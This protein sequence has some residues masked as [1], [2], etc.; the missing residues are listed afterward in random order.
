[1]L[2][3]SKINNRPDKLL[4]SRLIKLAFS[5][6]TL[7]TA[8]IL[9]FLYPE[10]H[11]YL[12]ALTAVLAS[13]CLLQT[14][15]TLD[16]G[17]E[18]ISYGGFA[19]EIIYNDFQPKRIENALGEA[20]IQNDPAKDLIKTLPVLNFLEQNLAEGSAN[21]ANFYRLQTACLNLTKE[22]TVLSLVLHREQDKIFNDLEWFEITVRP[23]YLKKTDIFEGPF[24]IKK[25]KKE[26]YLYWSLKNIT[27]AK[28]M[29]DVFQVE[30]KSLHD[31]IDDLPVGLY[32]VDKDST[33][34]YANRSFA[35]FLGLPCEELSGRALSDFLATNET[36]PGRRDLWH[37]DVSILQPQTTM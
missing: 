26:T 30:R 31:F 9:L 34:E 17:E 15:K 4:Q 37:L 2:C 24:S 3:N 18:A 19:N 32:T 14:I 28:N 29:E 11:L 7:T 25:I 6:V 27:A 8:I 33:I 22:K 21:K 13:L 36:L 20:I 16:A 1:M 35:D 23:I 5:L 10:Y 12:I